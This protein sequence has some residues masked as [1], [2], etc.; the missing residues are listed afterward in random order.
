MMSGLEAAGG[1]MV[2]VIIIAAVARP[3]AAATAH[4]CVLTKWMKINPI[5]TL[6]RLPPRKFLG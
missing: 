3:V 6:I 4:H 5:N 1:W 2:S